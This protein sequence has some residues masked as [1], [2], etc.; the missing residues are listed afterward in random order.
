MQMVRTTITLPSDLHEELLLR[1]IKERTTLSSLVVDEF[2][3]K[4]R[5]KRSKKVT[6]EER[7]KRDFALFDQVAS[8]GV[9]ID[10]VKAVRE[11]RNRDNNA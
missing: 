9:Q 7:L 2:Q 8:S 11:E 3:R 4:K 5:T 1:S 6:I 10:A